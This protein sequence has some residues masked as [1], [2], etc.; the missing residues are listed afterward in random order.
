MKERKREPA[1]VISGTRALRGGSGEG[2]RWRPKWTGGGVCLK[3]GRL[4]GP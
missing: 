1:G 4:G 3:G 2:A